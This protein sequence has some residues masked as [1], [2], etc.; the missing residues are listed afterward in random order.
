MTVFVA[1][2]GL[3]VVMTVFVAA[4]GLFVVMTVF[5]A[6]LGLFVVMTVF[7]VFS[8]IL[9]INRCRLPSRVRLF[10]QQNMTCG[11][12]DGRS[13]C[14]FDLQLKIMSDRQQSQPLPECF[15]RSSEI[16]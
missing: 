4:L 3:F 16:K 12:P 5:V 9:C 1:V 7:V 13:V 14:L 2:L 6:V 11:T 10:F 15:C 8:M